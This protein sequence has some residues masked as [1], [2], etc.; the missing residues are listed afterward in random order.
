MMQKKHGYIV[1]DYL[2]VN[3]GAEHLVITLAENLP[4]CVLAVSGICSEFSQSGDLSEVECLVFGRYFAKLPRIPRALLT[5]SRNISSLRDVE[6]VIYSGVYAPLAV[7]SQCYGKKIFYCHT[8]PRFAFD[9]EDRYV[10]RAMPMLRPIM[11]FAIDQYRGRYLNALRKMDV[12]V[13]NSN[14]VRER[15]RSL[16]G[17]DSQ[18]IYPPIDT[19][20]FRWTGQGDYYL[21]LGRLEPNKRVD[22]IVRAFLEMPDK[23]L[24]VTSGGSMLGAL[25]QLANGAPNIFFTGWLDESTLARLI[26][27]ALACIYVPRDEDFGMSAVEALAAGKPI[28]GVDEGGLRESM[29][30][31]ETGVLLPPDPT[32]DM[33]VE[34]VY[35]LPADACAS[36][37]FNCEK[38]A[39]FF[40]KPRFLSEM[41][42]LI[43]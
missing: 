18:V 27:N 8:P 35:G 4:N 42:K 16:V 43:R 10:G 23:K 3:G 15:L 26:G 12:I 37:R 21:S 17:L 25:K 5:F 24:V 38:R 13:T 20:R 14:H 34:A 11:R 30:E 40:S 33:I 28:I 39:N 32:P 31:G 6:W 29:I 2:Q 19:M 36:M 9:W 41:E 22:R 7:K 1:H